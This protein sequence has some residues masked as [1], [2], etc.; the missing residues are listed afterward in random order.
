M[1]PSLLIYTA[2][3]LF[4]APVMRKLLETWIVPG[5][6]MNGSARNCS[7]VKFTLPFRTASCE[8]FIGRPSESVMVSLIPSFIVVF[9]G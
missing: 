6:R 3:P 8:R 5:L 1:A 9:S 4:A 7:R 2:L